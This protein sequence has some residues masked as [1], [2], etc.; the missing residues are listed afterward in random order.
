MPAPS[1]GQRLAA[2]R[3]SHADPGAH[4]SP[5]NA[6]SEA[7]PRQVVENF[8]AYARQRIEAAILADME[9]VGIILSHARRPYLYT[10]LKV[11]GWNIPS[12]SIEDP[13]HEYH[14]TWKAFSSWC[15][16]NDLEPAWQAKHDRAEHE[17]WYELV[18]AP[19]SVA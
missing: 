1:L 11:Y 14:P 7:T 19:R 3:R 6:A 12:Q 13:A 9:P 5:A 18:V 2:L 8:F 17:H 4:G 10:V 16:A 15:E